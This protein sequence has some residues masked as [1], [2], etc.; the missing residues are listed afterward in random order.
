MWRLRLPDKKWRV[1]MDEL[2]PYISEAVA[3]RRHLH[4]HPELGWTE[5][6][7]TALVAEK[8]A[9]YGFEIHLGKEV[10]NLDAVYGRDPELVNKALERARKDGVSEDILK[11][12]DG[13]T[14]CVAILDTGKDGPS[15]GFRFDMDALPIL[16]S[17]DESHLP[18]KEGFASV[19]PGVMHAC[20]HD[21][22]TAIGIAFARWLSE[23]KKDLTGRIKL[24]FQPA[25]EGVRGAAAMA[26]AGVADDLDYIFGAHVGTRA[27]PGEIRLCTGGFFATTKFDVEFIGQAAHAGNAPEKGKDALFAAAS[28]VVM[29]RA[30]P[31]SSQG[32]TRITTG[33][34][35][36]G[37][38]RNIIPEHAVMICEVRGSNYD[39]KEYMFEKAMRVIEGAA[40]A[41][42]VT[43][44]VTIAGMAP[45]LVTTDK[46]LCVMREAARAIPGCTVLDEC[47]NTGSEDFCVFARRVKEKGGNPG[48]FLFG[49]E[50]HGHHRPDFD[51]QDTKSIPIGL[52]AFVNIAKLLSAS[53]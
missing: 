12:M 11:K 15:V 28:A 5:F 49:C 40:A 26:A 24:I 10:V 21:S 44:K 53:R 38:G 14:G 42:G 2:L 51:I 34:L 1:A 41:E 19:S 43:H 33:V 52:S 50:H 31:R 37:T 6:E 45:S 22:H 13:Y 39:A 3:I 23:H 27:K 48:Y 25:E 8:L 7:T 32:L 29:L 17:R 4:K 16:E 9:Q 36:A 20:G 47:G 35:K 18:F 30:I 46:A